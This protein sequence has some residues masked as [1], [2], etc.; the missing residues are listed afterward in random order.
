MAASASGEK[1][2]QA[3]PQ[4]SSSSGAG[5][6]VVAGGGAAQQ[7]ILLHRTLHMELLKEAGEM[8]AACGGDV[9]AIVFFPGGSRAEYHTFRGAPIAAARA[10]AVARRRREAEAAAAALRGVVAM[11]V[12]GMAAEEVEAHRRKLLA[13]K[14][15]VV[16]KLQEKAAAAVANVAAGDDDDAGRSNK[17]RKIDVLCSL[18]LLHLSQLGFSLAA[19]AAAAADGGEV[20]RPLR[21][22]LRRDEK[23][24]RYGPVI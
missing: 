7:I 21:H 12:S 20:R 19:A 18:L 11:D 5:A 23:Q 10:R 16:R 14:A 22:P 17:I 2:R 6:V 4:P 1:K 13:L 3:Q 9:H 24:M 8:A 15:A